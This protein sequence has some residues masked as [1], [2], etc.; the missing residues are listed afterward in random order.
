VCQIPPGLKEITCNSKND[1]GANQSYL[2]PEMPNFDCVE[3][4]CVTVVDKTVF[5]GEYECMPHKDAGGPVTLECGFGIKLTDGTHYAIDTSE[6]KSGKII[7]I[8]TG[9][10]IKI[11]GLMVPIQAI[12]SNQWQK[13]DIKGIIRASEL[14]KQ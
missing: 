2:T 14:A 13:Y 11:T 4:K 12:S 6:I 9:A 5:T 8:P 1:C 7:D 10:K 3:N